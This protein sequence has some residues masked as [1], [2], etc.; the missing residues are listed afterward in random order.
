MSTLPAPDGLTRR[1]YYDY[2]IRLDPQVLGLFDV[3]QVVTALSAELNIF[4][5]TLDTPL[6]TNPL[7]VPLKSPRLPRSAVTRE[8]FLPSRFDLPAATAAY[9]TCVAV[10]HHALLGNEADVRAIAEAVAKVTGHLDQFRPAGP[11]AVS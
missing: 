6:N 3:Q 9:H 11:G 5:E 8:L 10:L 1:T 2:V 7:Y 4:V